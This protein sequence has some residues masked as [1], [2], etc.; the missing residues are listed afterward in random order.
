MAAN[1]MNGHVNFLMF[2]C[3]YLFKY[4]FMCTANASSNGVCSN[5]FTISIKPRA[6]KSLVYIVLYS[7]WYIAKNR[8]SNR[9]QQIRMQI[10]DL[11]RKLVWITKDRCT[12]GWLKFLSLRFFLTISKRS[13]R[14]IKIFY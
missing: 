8:F 6:G 7:Y 13:R 4:S 2:V 11:A 14:K 9:K 12:I 5:N 1:D 10:V 3:N